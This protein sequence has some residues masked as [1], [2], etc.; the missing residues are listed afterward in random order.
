M[1]FVKRNK[2][3]VVVVVVESDRSQEA[4]RVTPLLTSCEF[5]HVAY[6]TS[7][8]FSQ[9]FSTQTTSFLLVFTF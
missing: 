9:W 8:H 1:I 6:C 3:V 5:I 2:D 7:G 4:L